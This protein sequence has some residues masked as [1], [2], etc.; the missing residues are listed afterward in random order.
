MFELRVVQVL[1]MRVNFVA[2]LSLNENKTQPAVYQA[3][4]FY[5]Q[6]FSASA[7]DIKKH[8]RNKFASSSFH[9]GS[10]EGVPSEVT[11]ACPSNVAHLF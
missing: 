9:I 3:W 5:V 2:L 4:T 6:Y 7:T 1:H 8:F 10:G 11:N